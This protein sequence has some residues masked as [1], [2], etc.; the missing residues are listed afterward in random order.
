MNKTVRCDGC[1][2][3]LD[4]EL[5]SKDIYVV[6]DKRYCYECALKLPKYI[7][8]RCSQC[9]YFC[10]YNYCERTEKYVDRNDDACEKY[11]SKPII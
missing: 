11:E 4:L 2:K 8:K 10:F 6:Y 1:G 3:L 7:M 5:C 9:K